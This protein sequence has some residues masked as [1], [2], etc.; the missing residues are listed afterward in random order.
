MAELPKLHGL[1][2]ERAHDFISQKAV[3]D[4]RIEFA[5]VISLPLEG[6][7]YLQVKIRAG[8]R[9]YRDQQ[10]DNH[11]KQQIDPRQ[12]E[13]GHRRFQ[14]RDEKFLRTVMGKFRDVE[15]V[16]GN[17]GHNLPYLGVVKIIVGQLL[18]MGERVLSHIG[19]D[20]RSHHMPGIGHIVTRHP[21]D[22]AQ[23]K[24]NPSDGENHTQGQRLQI[25]HPHI[26]EI[27][28]HQRQYHLTD[29]RQCRA[30][31]IRQHNSRILPIIWKK[32]F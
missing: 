3:L 6:F 32:P 29:R 27:A 4:P 12:N 2:R 11:R 20:G 18:Q 10:K 1:V 22:D 8:N 7:S 26:G 14:K 17:P 28:Q 5:D 19:L 24:I 23:Q 30:Q 16:A 15:K 21:V 25:V 13:E 31:Q 9:H